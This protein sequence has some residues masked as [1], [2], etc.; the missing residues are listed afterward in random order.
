[1]AQCNDC[2]QTP[3]LNGDLL[4]TACK[5]SG[6]VTEVKVSVPKVPKVKKGKK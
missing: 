4:C 5:G 1:M 2:L 6:R 3:G